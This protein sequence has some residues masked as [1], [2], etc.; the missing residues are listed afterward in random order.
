[1]NS[2]GRIGSH[3]VLGASL[4]GE[5][6]HGRCIPAEAASGRCICRI[7]QDLK[8]DCFIGAD[9]FSLGGE[10]KHR[11]GIDRIG[12]GIGIAHASGAEVWYHDIL[13]RFGRSGLVLEHLC[14]EVGVSYVSVWNNCRHANLYQSA[15]NDFFGHIVIGCRHTTCCRIED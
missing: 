10:D 6:R 14:L 13:N 4:D 7:K 1:M 2:T 8:V 11:L 9:G 15:F 5:V 12:D 3:Q